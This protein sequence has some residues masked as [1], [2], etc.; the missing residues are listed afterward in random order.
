[1]NFSRWK[2]KKRNPKA[3]QRVVDHESAATAHFPVCLNTSLFFR[4]LL[5]PEAGPIHPGS[6]QFQVNS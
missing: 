5:T 4:G 2:K 6:T 1:M 3:K